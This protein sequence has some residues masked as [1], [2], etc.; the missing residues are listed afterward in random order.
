M[1]RIPVVLV[2]LVVSVGTLTGQTP[3]NCSAQNGSVLTGV[4]RNGATQEPIRSRGVHVTSAGRIAC[5]VV[6]D[7]QGR[8]VM[9]GLAAGE[10]ALG[11]GDL[12]YRRFSPVPVVLNGADTAKFDIELQPVG[13]FEDCSATPSCASWTVPVNDPGLSQEEQF[14]LAAFRLAV[15]LAR[16][17]PD[18]PMTG[19]LC[20]GSSSNVL[21]ALRNEYPRTAPAN[22]CSVDNNAPRRATALRHNT[23][24]EPATLLFVEGQGGGSNSPIDSQKLLRRPAAPRSIGDTVREIQLGRYAGPRSSAVWTCVLRKTREGWV[25]ASCVM[26]WIA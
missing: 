21:R 20:V 25:P 5:M 7:S 17:R 22:E 24:G 11:V 4:V 2:L 18:L 3:R 12:G 14:E 15:V 16:E 6:S 26:D 1:Q 13:P 23:T 9:S 10:Y 19:Y 8:F